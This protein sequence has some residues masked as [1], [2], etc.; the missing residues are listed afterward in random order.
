MFGTPVF[1]VRQCGNEFSRDRS[2][3]RVQ[4]IW[5]CALAVIFLLRAVTAAGKNMLS[6][7]PAQ[8]NLQQAS[9]P[10]YYHVLRAHKILA[11]WSCGRGH[12]FSL[13]QL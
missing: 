13:Q 11:C 9:M 1:R 2:R 12:A 8:C 4:R 3:H 10:H 6:D 5:H 7:L